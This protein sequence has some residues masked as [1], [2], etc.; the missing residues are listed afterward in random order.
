MWMVWFG[1]AVLAL[2]AMRQV[3]LRW[4]AARLLKQGLDLLAQ[5]RFDEA[6]QR[7]DRLLVLR[8]AHA[9]ALYQRGVALL[10]LKRYLES[11]GSEQ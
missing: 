2:L 7:L 5:K 1:A 4:H 11:I 3:A 6:L 8:P 10:S 9:A